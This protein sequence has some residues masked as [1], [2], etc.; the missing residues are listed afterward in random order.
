VGGSCRSG[1]LVFEAGTCGA[2]RQYAPGGLP[3]GRGKAGGVEEGKCGKQGVGGGGWWC[4]GGVGER[5]GER[6]ASVVGL[7]GCGVVWSLWVGVG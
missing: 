5:G 3:C 4:V 1:A 2:S 7:L 6:G